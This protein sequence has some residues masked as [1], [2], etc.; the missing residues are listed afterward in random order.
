MSKKKQL[1]KHDRKKHDF[2]S[3]LEN[4]DK[5]RFRPFLFDYSKNA[6]RWI[7]NRTIK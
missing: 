5:N 2:F 6:I 1:R 7:L 3:C 4:N